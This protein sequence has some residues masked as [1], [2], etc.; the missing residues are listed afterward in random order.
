[1]LPA[2]ASTTCMIALAFGVLAF[3]EFTITRT[4]GLLTSSIMVIC[5]IADTTLLPA[6][7]SR[8]SLARPASQD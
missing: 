1:V 5:F 7:L 4:L 6:L 8:S 3:S 2:I